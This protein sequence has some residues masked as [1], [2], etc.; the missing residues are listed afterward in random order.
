MLI[1]K[2]A[3]SVTVTGEF[4]RSKQIALVPDRNV[5]DYAELNA[6]NELV[7]SADV[8]SVTMRHVVHA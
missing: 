1:A 7:N 5:V 8:S 4:G 3:A 6:Q 2:G